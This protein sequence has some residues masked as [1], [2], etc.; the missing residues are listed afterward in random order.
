MSVSSQ[1]EVSIDRKTVLLTILISF[2]VWFS[3]FH[4][5]ILK[6]IPLNIDSLGSYSVFKF[7][8]NNVF[9]GVIPLW[10]PFIYYGVPQILIIPSGVLNPF[11]FLFATTHV[12]VGGYYQAYLFYIVFYYWFGLLGFYLLSKEVLENRFYALIAFLLLCFSGMG[13]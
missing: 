12:L 5:F 11:S 6:N 7:F 13:G 2:I 1:N 3:L 10:N 4:Q 9:N 8:Y